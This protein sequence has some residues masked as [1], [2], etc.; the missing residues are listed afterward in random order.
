MASGAVILQVIDNIS[1][2]EVDMFPHGIRHK[3]GPLSL[4]ATSLPAG[5]LPTLNPVCPGVDQAQEKLDKEAGPGGEK[6]KKSSASK[7]SPSPPF[8]SQ[9][10][11]GSLGMMV[12]IRR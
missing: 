7:V 12:R 4:E 8:T 9:P 1:C 2:S 5:P 6:K 3:K 10:L 11:Q